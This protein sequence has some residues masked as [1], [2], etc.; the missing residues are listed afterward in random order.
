MQHFWRQ[1]VW[2]LGISI[3]VTAAFAGL[4]V[5]MDP[6]WSV[7]PLSTHMRVS[8]R[9][10][11][12]SAKD[13][14]AP[15]LGTYQVRETHV[16]VTVSGGHTVAAIVRDPLDGPSDRAAVVLMHGAGT[17][18]A[19]EVYG[20]VATDL[21]SAG[22]TSIVQD[23]RLDNYTAL[24]RDYDAS[25]DDYLAAVEV[26]R[27]WDGVDPAKVG[28][29]AE[30]EGTWIATIMAKKDP[31]LDFVALTSPPVYSG[32]QQMAMAATECLNIIGAPDG[33]V[34]LI[35]RLTSLD[36]GPFGLK[37]AD[38]DAADYRGALT[39]PV[40]VNYGT[41]DPSMPIEQGAQQ[42]I[43]DTHEVGNDNVTVRY[44]PTNHQMRTGSS[45]S[46]PGLPLAEHYTENL[47]DWINDVAAGTAADGWQTPLIAGTQPF[48][49]F[50]VPMDMEPGLIS[51]VTML[52]AIFLFGVLMWGA[53]AVMCL[54]SVLR[55][56]RTSPTSVRKDGR[57]VSHRFAM[58]TKAL[59]VSTLLLTAALTIAFMAYFVFLAKA[60]LA[61]SDQSAMLE[62][63]W[64]CL[65]VAVIVSIVLVSWIMVR[66]YF[67][68]GPGR[69]DP[70]TPK[71]VDMRMSAGHSAV[72]AC[73]GLCAASALVLGSF[74]NLVP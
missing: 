50:A 2:T 24:S 1:I 16:T 8:D 39:M 65:R 20:D 47:A 26:L 28:I 59:I 17:G 42:I 54:V 29:Y 6:G 27:G 12:I 57:T 10:T 68:Y 61:L 11:A 3:I 55:R 7:G 56:K 4:S 41:R 63:G 70:D 60:A 21:A 14:T 36:F 18:K 38:F 25:A 23:K 40:L 13:T 46:V 32:R 31:T 9:D 64:A 66:K 49:E 35:P 69:I 72:I 71:E 52:L 44:Y 51:S 45:L 33:V 15:K 5:A 19:A 53:V 58:P 43:K 30:S 37:Y 48:Q 73:C 67:F 62:A 22:I 74:F 34:K